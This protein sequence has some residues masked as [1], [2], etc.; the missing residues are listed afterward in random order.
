M[1]SIFLV[2]GTFLM[3][4]LSGCVNTDYIGDTYT[5]TSQVDVYYSIDDVKQSHV[6]M[7]KI[8]ATAAD[9][10][11]CTVNCASETGTKDSTTDLLHYSAAFAKPVVWAIAAWSIVWRTIRRGSARSATGP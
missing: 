9:G 5:P 7:G 2:I 11:D 10:W 6:I 8:T 4:L 3:A 1:K